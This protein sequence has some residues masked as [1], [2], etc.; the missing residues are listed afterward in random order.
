LLRSRKQMQLILLLPRATH[1]TAITTRPLDRAQSQG[2]PRQGVHRALNAHLTKPAAAHAASAIKAAPYGPVQGCGVQAQL[3]E[4]LTLLASRLPDQGAALIG[5]ASLAGSPRG[6]IHNTV[7]GQ[8]AQLLSHLNEHIRSDDHD[9]RYWLRGQPVDDANRLQG[10]DA[11]AFV[12]A[13]YQ[14]DDRYLRRV[15]FQLIPLNAGE[16]REVTTLR[17]RPDVVSLS[18][19]TATNTSSDVTVFSGEHTASLQAW[20]TRTATSGGSDYKLT[21]RNGSPIRLFV[22]VVAFNAG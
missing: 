21:V 8:L 4:I 7:R 19:M 9:A 15:F 13:D 14:H 5:N 11:A 12:R 20:V 2:D 3:Q 16:Q 10:L 22:R 6:V 17:D 1:R 18:Y